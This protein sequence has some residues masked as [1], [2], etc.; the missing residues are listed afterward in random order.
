MVR[1]TGALVLLLFVAVRAASPQ[2]ASP[3]APKKSAPPEAAALKEAD[4]LVREIYK[5]EYARTSPADVKALAQKLLDKEP[6]S[7]SDLPASFVLLRDAR[8]LAASVG[9]VEIAFGAI[10]R[11]EEVFQIDAPPMKV[12]VL[13]AAARRATAPDAAK[14]V[15]DAYARLVEDLVAARA[16]ESAKAAAQKGEA[17]AKSS[18]QPALAAQIKSKAAEIERG[19]KEDQELKAAQKTVADKP[20]DPAANQA[21]GRSLCFGR[22]AWDEGLPYLAKAADPAL[23]DVARRDLSKAELPQSQIEIGEA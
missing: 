6:E 19:F 18:K 3:P 10:D 1:R 13:E 7:R 11:M 16:F 12:R 4:K 23:Q 2:D 5:A 22:G 9:D 8:D 21:V 17:F 15:G 14:A 20:D